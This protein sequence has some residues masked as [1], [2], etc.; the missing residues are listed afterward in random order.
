[1]SVSKESQ[2]LQS[3]SLIRRF[4]RNYLMQFAFFRLLKKYALK[5]WWPLRNLFVMFSMI[6]K[7]RDL[8]RAYL[9]RYWFF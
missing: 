2:Q 4:Y 3:V 7:P 5:V 8:Y 1:M 9:S 6:A